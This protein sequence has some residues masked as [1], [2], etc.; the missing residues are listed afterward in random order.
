[1]DPRHFGTETLR[2]CSAGSEVSGHFGTSTEVSKR[3]FGVGPKYRTVQPHGPNCPAIWT[4]V[5]HP[6][7]QSV[8]P[9]FAVCR[10]VKASRQ[11]WPR[12]QIILPRPQPRPH[13]FWPR[14]HAQLASLTSLAVFVACILHTAHVHTYMTAW[15]LVAVDEIKDLLSARELDQTGFHAV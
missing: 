10:D 1:M 13:S 7:V 5:S 3:H 4:G 14:P 2:H 11:M 15:P 9:K 12:G 6:M 8:S